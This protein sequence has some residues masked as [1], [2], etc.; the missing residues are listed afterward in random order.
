MRIFILKSFFI[1]SFFL[2]SAPVF[3]SGQ[4]TEEEI[5]DEILYNA[6]KFAK[7]SYKNKFADLRPQAV[8]EAAQTLGFQKGVQWRYE[9]I[10][11]N[12]LNQESQINRIFD[13]GGLLMNNGRILPPVIIEGEKG[14][15]IES[16]LVATEVES[17]FRILKDARIVSVP[18]S[19]RDYLYREYEASRVVNPAVLPK[20]KEEQDLWEEYAKKGFNEGVRHADRLFKTNLQK[21]VR[22][23]EGILRFKILAEQNIVSLPILSKGEIGIVVEDKKLDVDQRI[24]RITKEG[25]F[26]DKVE[27]WTPKVGEN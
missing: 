20:G 8:I 9:K 23:F 4:A 25:S 19:W 7:D 6:E 27:T 5:L 13:F 21:M 11:E 17:S 16:N 3:G 12:V 26:N 14:L 15:N 18:P 24:F 10:M 22:D 2:I 1:I